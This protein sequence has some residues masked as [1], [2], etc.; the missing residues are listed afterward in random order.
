M[1]NKGDFVSEIPTQS[2]TFVMQWF[3]KRI[4]EEMIYGAIMKNSEKIVKF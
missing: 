3:L 1:T 4:P 2:R